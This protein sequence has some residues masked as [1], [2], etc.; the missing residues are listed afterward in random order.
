MKWDRTFAFTAFLCAA[1]FG[2]NWSA[3][4]QSNSNLYCRLGEEREIAGCRVSCRHEWGST[5]CPN[6]CIASVPP[7]FALINHRRV[8]WSNRRGSD[9]V[10]RVSQGQTFSYENDIKESYSR[11]MQAAARAGKSD[12]EANL[13]A[14]MDRAVSV[15]QRIFSSH[16]AIRIEVNANRPP[17][18]IDGA[19]WRDVEVVLNVVCL[20]PPNMTEQLLER[21]GL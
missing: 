10:T 15:A 6:S 19:N 4:A 7:G 12:V 20:V 9:S 3:Q 11:A 8:E 13:K 5:T 1:S 2:G 14:E 18:P 16:Q 17:N 21:Y